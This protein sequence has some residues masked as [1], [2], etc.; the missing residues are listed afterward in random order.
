VA[1]QARKRRFIGFI[2][3]LQSSSFGSL[4]AL[5][6]T[7]SPSTQVFFAIA[8]LGA[9]S[10]LLFIVAFPS[11]LAPW[12]GWFA[13]VPVGLALDRLQQNKAFVLMLLTATAGWLMATW[14]IVPGVMKQAGAQLHTALFF[15]ILFCLF[16]ALPYGLAAWLSSHHNG[17]ASISGAFGSAIVWTAVINAFPLV[18]PG[19]L[20][21]SQYQYPLAFQVLDLGGV[22]LLMFV[23]QLCNW[24]LVVAV[25]RRRISPRTALSALALAA[26][27]VAANF[28]YGHLRLAQINQAE[29]SG[30]EYPSLSVGIV[31]PNIP[32][33]RRDPAATQDAHHTLEAMTRKLAAEGAPLIIWPEVPIH[34]SHASEPADRRWLQELVR[35]TGTALLLT[36]YVMIDGAPGQR[37]IYFNSVEWLRDGQAAEIYHKRLL[38]PFA[39]YMPGEQLFPY[40]RTIFPQASDYRPGAQARVFRLDNGAV[41]IPAICYEAVFSR[42]VAEGVRLGGNILVNQVDD[43]W[44]GR[45]DGPEIHLALALYRSVEFRLPIIRVANSGISGIILPSGEFAAGSRTAQYTPLTALHQITLR[46]PDSVYARYGEL[47]LPILYALALLLVVRAE[48][49]HRTKRTR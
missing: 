27:V 32:V 28:T 8:G 35:S 22:P 44:F 25:V 41:L 7:L 39:E 29:P 6:R 26:T 31:Q 30:E 5:M 4:Y 3:P 38:L 47:V 19:S 12:A 36:G 46:T 20:A 16:S 21:H 17:F 1:L 10:S 37:P 9:L 40:L 2:A 11:G 33:E 13:W 48:R 43:A 42:L 24:L 14:W 15:H 34:L 49:H 18:L 23:M 45:T